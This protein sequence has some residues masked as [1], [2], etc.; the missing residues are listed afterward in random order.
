MKGV[1]GLICDEDRN[2]RTGEG[3]RDTDSKP[4]PGSAS[5]H[6]VSPKEVQQARESDQETESPDYPGIV[7]DGNGKDRDVIRGAILGR[8]AMT[9]PVRLRPKSDDWAASEVVEGEWYS[10]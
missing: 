6:R 7:K 5:S 9:L 2:N 10:L 1:R 4:V 8:I 3:G